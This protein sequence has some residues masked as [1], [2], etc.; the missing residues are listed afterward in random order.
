MNALNI[1]FYNTATDLRH[2]R[3]YQVVHKLSKHHPIP[4]RLKA[5][6]ML[7]N[8]NRVQKGVQ[9]ILSLCLRDVVFVNLKLLKVR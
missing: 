5:F 1:P 6:H 7:Q 4:L 3:L 8:V 9:K 2:R